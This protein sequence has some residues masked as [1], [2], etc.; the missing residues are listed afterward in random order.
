MTALLHHQ[1]TVSGSREHP[2]RPA[3]DGRRADVDHESVPVPQSGVVTAVSVRT[4]IVI[5]RPPQQV[6]AYAADPD[7]VTAWYRNI[8]TVEWVT[9]KPLAVG[10][11]IRFVATFLGRRL[12]YV[13]VIRELID[14][15]RLVMVTDEGPF[16]MKTTYTWTAIG[17]DRTLM[18][19]VNEGEPTGF[20]K[21]SAPAI[22][23]A[24]RRANRKD[25]AELKSILESTP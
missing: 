15:Q 5:D 22:T 21:L 19:L 24:M 1:D 11:Q 20:A 7:N 14:G 16:P 2:I 3:R 4:E 9:S 25:L 13:Y 12:A 23:A 10:S 17:E 6:S 18:V 8:D